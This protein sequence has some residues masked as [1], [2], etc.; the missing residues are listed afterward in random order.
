MRKGLENEKK[1][2]KLT[3]TKVYVCERERE[4]DRE[5]E[6]ERVSTVT[7]LNVDSDYVLFFFTSDQL[8]SIDKALMHHNNS[9]NKSFHFSQSLSNLSK[10]LFFMA[11][12][13][14]VSNDFLKYFLKDL[15]I[16]IFSSHLDL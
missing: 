4:R 7:L 16:G 9:S 15:K 5:R 1:S 10:L 14:W 11:I 8:N 3:K 6:R 2:Q 12:Y 13:L